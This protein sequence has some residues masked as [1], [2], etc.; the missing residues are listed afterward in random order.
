MTSRLCSHAVRAIAVGLTICANLVWTQPGSAKGVMDRVFEPSPVDSAYATVWANTETTI[1]LRF[2]PAL[3]RRGPGQV[4]FTDDDGHGAVTITAVPQQI[5][6]ETWRAAFVLP[7]AGR[8]EGVHLY[9]PPFAVRALPAQ[10]TADRTTLDGSIVVV[11]GALTAA[12][13]AIG[14]AFARRRHT[15]RPLR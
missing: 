4:R 6:P 2:D 14:T 10:G 7:H 3:A 1:T 12:A 8:W 9:S 5:D 13:A 15:A 11:T